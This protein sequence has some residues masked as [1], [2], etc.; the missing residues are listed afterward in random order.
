LGPE[1]FALFFIALT[2]ALLVHDLGRPERSGRLLLKRTTRSWLVKGAWILMCFG[3]VEALSVDGPADRQA[4]HRRTR[5]DVALPW[6]MSCIGIQ[7]WL[8][9]Q[10][11]GRDCG[12]RTGSSFAR[13]CARRCWA[14]RSR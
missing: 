4:T 7:R 10:C 11:R 1:L 6:A 3:G 5:C 12:S 14:R 8:F 13:V 2:S 9:A